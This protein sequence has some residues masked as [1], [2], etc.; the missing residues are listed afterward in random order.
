VLFKGLDSLKGQ[1]F[2]PYK[3]EVNKEKKTMVS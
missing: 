1:V 2:G 3:A